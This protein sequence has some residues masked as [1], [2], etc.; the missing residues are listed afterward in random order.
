MSVSEGSVESRL[1]VREREM[2][3]LIVNERYTRSWRD[4]FVVRM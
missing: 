2:S 4:G 1:C 3:L